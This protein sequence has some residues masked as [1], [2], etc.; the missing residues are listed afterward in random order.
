MLITPPKPLCVQDLHQAIADVANKPLVNS[1]LERKGNGV[2]LFKSIQD[3]AIKGCG[4]SG[5]MA[6]S[7][8]FLSTLESR[9]LLTSTEVL[10][11][12]Q[13]VLR[14][15]CI[16]SP[17]QCEFP[18]G[19]SL[20]R[21]LS[22]YLRIMARS[23]LLKQAV[24]K[25]IT[26][27]PVKSKPEECVLPEPGMQE[28]Y[29]E[30]KSM[31]KQCDNY[32]SENQNSN[33]MTERQRRLFL[34]RLLLPFE[35]ILMQY[36]MTS[37]Y[38]PCLREDACVEGC[39]FA[40]IY[41]ELE[42]MINELEE[43]IQYSKCLHE[44]I[45][46]LDIK[47][48]LIVKKEFSDFVKLIAFQR[49]PDEN[50]PCLDG[51]EINKLFDTEAL[52]D[53]SY[54]EHIKLQSICY[55]FFRRKE[56]IPIDLAE[57]SLKYI[58][59]NCM[60]AHLELDFSYSNQGNLIGFI[61]SERYSV[62]GSRFNSDD[63]R[64]GDVYHCRSFEYCYAAFQ[65][66][67]NVHKINLCDEVEAEK[68]FHQLWRYDYS[69]VDDDITWLVSLIARA[70][71]RPDD[72]LR[73]IDSPALT[74]LACG[75]SENLKKDENSGL[76]DMPETIRQFASELIQLLQHHRERDCHLAQSIYPQR[77]WNEKYKGKLPSSYF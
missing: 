58:C 20:L 25:I 2:S 31:K 23:P 30:L 55:L 67:F 8:R 75:F 4:I 68:F 50:I 46:R 44:R 63:Q 28:L 54:A 51:M 62:L 47:K 36:P 66:W 18:L 22:G 35:K 56:G 48:V 71:L 16:I 29:D 52:L 12:S 76:S 10:A 73:F 17:E 5:S 77:L 7:L 39:S 24:E 32:I 33:V 34:K 41:K 60:G 42:N 13:G 57:K 43:A 15:E 6:D 14:Q 11:L 64:I 45:D 38:V 9:Q 49:L 72:R 26:D 53:S 27:A 61:G 19:I 21:W 69:K 37:R 65:D 74:C 3:R 40:N 59:I 70:G 1:Q